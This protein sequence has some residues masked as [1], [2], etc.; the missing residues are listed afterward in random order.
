MS[1]KRTWNEDTPTTGDPRKHGATQMVEAWYD[2][3]DRTSTLTALSLDSWDGEGYNIATAYWCSSAA[4]VAADSSTY[5]AVQSAHWW[6]PRFTCDMNIEYTAVA[7]A[8]SSGAVHLSMY[9]DVDGGGDSGDDW[10]R[11]NLE[12]VGGF[13]SRSSIN[14][15]TLHSGALAGI[16]TIQ[17]HV[18]SYEQ[19]VALTQNLIT[20]S[21][22][23]L[24][25]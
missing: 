19:D 12:S 18:R 2:I 15:Q 16:H 7:S 8:P 3:W 1:L 4:S 17:V 24:D 25:T 10:M 21:P 13:V 22:I 11:V 5:T 6:N 23:L 20:I 14:F 9:F